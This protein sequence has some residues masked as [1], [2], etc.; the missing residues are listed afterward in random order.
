[1]VDEFPKALPQ[2]GSPESQDTLR[3]HYG[4]SLIGDTQT[5]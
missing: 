3:H 2:Y 1:M 4:Q 5:T